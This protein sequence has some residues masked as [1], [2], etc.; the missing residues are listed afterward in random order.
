[1]RVITGTARG[2][3][4]Q[5]LDGITT[6]PTAERVKEALFSI[7]QFE[8]E[9]RR[10]LDLFAGSGQLGLEAI[11]RGAAR[12]VFVDSSRSAVEIVQKNIEACGFSA[13]CDVVCTDYNSYLAS[14]RE[15]F[16]IVL[17]DP[18]YDTGILEDAL[19]RCERSVVPGG[20]VV[21]EHPS[22]QTLPPQVGTLICHKV[23]RYGKVGVTVYRKAVEE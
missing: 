15:V 18:P 5:T 13:Q 23:Y 4:L 14:G 16:D 3:R 22:T 20:V 9:G 17:L 12:C 11:S 1:M 21:C 7:L 19:Q 10:V 6:R 2:R 8:L